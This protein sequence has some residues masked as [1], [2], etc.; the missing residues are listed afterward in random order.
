[1]VGGTVTPE[2]GAF[3]SL[4]LQYLKSKLK[5]INFFDLN[6]VLHRGSRAMIWMFQNKATVKEVEHSSVF[7]KESGLI[8]R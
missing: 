5:Y 8:W 3:H 4:H 2:K 7:F 6:N 1:M